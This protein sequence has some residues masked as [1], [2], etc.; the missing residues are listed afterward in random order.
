MTTLDKTILLGTIMIIIGILLFVKYTY[1]LI[2]EVNDYEVPQK[3]A[4]RLVLYMVSIFVLV[5]IG[6]ILLGITL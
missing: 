2:E 5:I 3:L 1:I 6:S 4:F